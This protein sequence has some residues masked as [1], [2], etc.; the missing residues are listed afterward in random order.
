[1]HIPRAFYPQTGK[2]VVVGCF[3]ANQN[4]VSVLLPPLCAGS[5]VS[6][7]AYGGG[8]GLAEGKSQGMGEVKIM[9]P[10]K[11]AQWLKM[12]TKQAR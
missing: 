1:M 5:S 11:K 7:P 12:S 10:S 2:H 3:S 8:H 6:D 4:R 9:R